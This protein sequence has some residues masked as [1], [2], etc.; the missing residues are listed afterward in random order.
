MTNI[1]SNM[2][3]A[4]IAV[5]VIVVIIYYLN[6]NDDQ[7]IPNH[8]SIYPN[9]ASQ[10][11]NSNQIIKPPLQ[12]PQ[13]NTRRCDEI[14]DSIVDELVSTRYQNSDI[15][16]DNNV[17][18]FS[19]SDP[20]MNAYGSFDGYQKKRQLNMK[21][22]TSPYCD[23][24]YDPRDFSYKKKSFTRRTP[25]DVK[26]QFDVEKMLPNEIE[27]DWFDVE[28]L[29]GT[30]KIKGPHLIH[31]KTQMGVNTVGSSKK[32]ATHDIRGDIP[33]PKT[34]VSPWLI[35]SIEPDTNL[36]GICNPI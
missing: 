29:Q 34:N 21:D 36:M 3:F 8:G 1:N 4:I 13:Y 26:D 22:V 11:S 17:G 12:P 9:T 2:M 35:S 15:P 27:E 30:K 20:M 10:S 25:E 32:N 14:S 28:P 7:P 6:K 18:T 24:D 5:I 33:N 23:D 31:P 19:P 16:I